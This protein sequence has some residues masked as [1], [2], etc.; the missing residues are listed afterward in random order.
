MRFFAVKTR[1]EKLSQKKK[2][3][4]LSENEIIAKENSRDDHK[5]VLKQKLI[6][7]YFREVR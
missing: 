5:E 3:N 1:I 6:E 2:K 4:K 7:Y